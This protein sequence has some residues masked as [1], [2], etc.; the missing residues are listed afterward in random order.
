MQNLMDLKNAAML[1]FYAPRRNC[2]ESSK[3]FGMRL[4]TG[5]KMKIETRIDEPSTPIDSWDTISARPPITL[6]FHASKVALLID[7]EN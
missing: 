7:F 3:W 5:H 4:A 1:G 2:Q 6:R